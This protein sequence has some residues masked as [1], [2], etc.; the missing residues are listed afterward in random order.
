MF[1]DITPAKIGFIGLGLIGGS[2]AKAIRTYF[3]D[4]ELIAFDKNK[5]TLALAVQENIIDTS[6]SAIDDN[7]K[8]CSYIFLCAPVS[9]NTACLT[10]LKS[11]IDPDCILTDV[12][13]VK[14]EIHLKIEELG[15][16]EYFIGGHPMVGSEKA[17]FSF[18]SDRLVENAYYFITPTK[19]VS[20]QSV[21]DFTNFIEELGALT[22]IL[23]Y[24]QHDAYTAAISHVPHIMAAELVHIVS[25]MDTDDG[26]LK[27]LA[28]GGFKDI[29]RIASS[30]P[31]VWEQISLSNKKNIKELL[32]KAQNHLGYVIA[33]LDMEDREYLNNYFKQAGEYRDSVPDSAVGLIQKSYEIF[34]DI[35][36]E[37]GTIATTTTLL[38]LNH[39]SI[40]NIGIIHNR[41][42]EEGVLKI[43]LY[44][45]ES[46]KKATKIL[47]DKNYTVYERK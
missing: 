5:E 31:V 46:A 19:K 27:Q 38:A 9:Y 20:E 35:P 3:P 6:C 28:A 37:P 23:D 41:E 8:G 18:S 45:D 10:Q 42:F 12:G 11:L 17:G 26:I 44:D 7:F 14:E 40:K 34:I 39:V 16:E 29:T 47:R 21:K 24:K 15:M 2:V 1:S 4:Y 36:D 13:S 25:N 32:Q 33:A 30:S 43:M 22:I